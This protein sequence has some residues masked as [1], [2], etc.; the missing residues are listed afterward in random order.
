M[1]STLKL[2]LLIYV[3]TYSAYSLPSLKCLTYLV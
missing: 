2:F 1:L 3:L